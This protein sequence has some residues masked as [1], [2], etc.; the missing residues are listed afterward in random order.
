VVQ[1]T[2]GRAYIVQSDDWLSKLALEFYGDIDLYTLIVDGTNAKA[3]EDPTFLPIDDPDAIE[4]GQK[5][6]IPPAP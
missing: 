1:P 4:V 5:L 6:W 2:T 3:A